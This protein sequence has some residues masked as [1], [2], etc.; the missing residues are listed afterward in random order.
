MGHQLSNEALA[1]QYLLGNLKDGQLARVERQILSSDEF[2]DELLA[3]ED[4]LTD[5]YLLNQLSARERWIFETRFLVTPERRRKLRFARALRM[6]LSPAERLELSDHAGSSASGWWK[7][8]YVS[9]RRLDLRFAGFPVAVMALLAFTGVL[10]IILPGLRYF[11]SPRMTEAQETDPPAIEKVQPSSASDE[12]GGSRPQPPVSDETVPA[13]TRPREPIIS[14]VLTAGTVRGPGE[15][16]RL[17]IPADKRARVRLI[18]LLTKQ[19]YSTYRAELQTVDGNS[20]CRRDRLKPTAMRSGRKI[21]MDVEAGMFS[22]NDY[23][24][25][26]EGIGPDGTPEAVGRYRLRALKK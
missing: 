22:N 4:D 3:A 15:T 12:P 23:S 13:A 26:L 11:V 18:L 7:R 6:Y 20:V 1:R 8:W 5:E 2:F 24:V 19:D 25:L 21:V 9:F 14:L 16:I 17:L 10:M